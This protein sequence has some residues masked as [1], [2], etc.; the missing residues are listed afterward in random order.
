MLYMLDT[1]ICSYTMRKGSAPILAALEARVE[2]GHQICISVITYTELRLGAERSAAKNK[3]HH[4]LDEFAD[5]L[6]L[7][8]DWTRREADR[9]AQIQ[10]RLFAQGSPIG[11]N[12][13]MIAAHALSLNTILVTNNQ[14]HFSQV[15]GLVIENWLQ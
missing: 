15:A 2:A 4:L 6:D 12:D 10:A 3:Y 11:Q 14:R 5:R 13:T 8:A 7:I 9:F 1:D